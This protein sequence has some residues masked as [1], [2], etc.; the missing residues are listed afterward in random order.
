MRIIRI[1]YAFFCCFLLFFLER[2]I[3]FLSFFGI[4]SIQYSC[5]LL[6][7]P[8]FRSGDNGSAQ[9]AGGG[10]LCGASSLVFTQLIVDQKNTKT[11]LKEQI[12]AKLIKNFLNKKDNIFPSNFDEKKSL[13]FLFECCFQDDLCKNI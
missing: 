8:L 11:F 1:F 13:L 2:K 7:C 3:K 4:R 12:C 5:F 6:L 9:A 10:P